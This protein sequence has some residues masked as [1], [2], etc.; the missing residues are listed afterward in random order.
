MRDLDFAF[1]EPARRGR[2][3][4]RS[5]MPAPPPPTRRKRRRKRRRGRSFAAF[6]IVL[7]LLGGLAAG[8]FFA[9]QWLRGNLSTPDYAGPGHGSVIIE[10]AQGETA[11]QI[12][13]TLYENDVVASPEAFIEAA[14]ANLESRNIQSGTYE[15]QQQ[16]RASDA[17]LLLLDPEKS[18]VV[19]LVTIPEGLSKFH[20]YELL[21]EELGIPAEDF[22]EAEETALE[23]IPEFWFERTDGKEAEGTI[24]G[25]L[26][27]NTYDF[28]RDA[29]AESVLETMV[30]HFLA[31]AED[32]D[33]ADRVESERGI[34]PYEALIAAS[35]AQAEAGI[36]DDLGKVARV[37]Y[38]RVYR[39]A[40]RLQ[41]DVTTNYGLLAQ[42]E[43]GVTSGE[44]SQEMLHDPDN[45]YSTHAH[46]GWPPGPIDSPGQVALEAAMEPAEGDWLFFV[47]IEPETGESAFASTDAEHEENKRIA[48]ENGVPIEC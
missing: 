12:A 3:V 47:L 42:G 31:V 7:L 2:G 41:M 11:T 48:C 39:A 5:G 17:L 28:G 25:F 38:N 45:R 33:F 46:D 24:E 20:T 37:A 40:M 8:G 23:L 22:E 43:E 15:L 13:Y 29:T 10:V 36:E 9:M 16:M 26:Y 21:A 44:M 27:P 34:S 19:E 6:L 14:D 1:E 30:N 18:L 35:I 4:Y 32:L